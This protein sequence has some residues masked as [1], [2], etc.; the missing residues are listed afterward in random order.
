MAPGVIRCRLERSPILQRTS[1][2]KE[3][4]AAEKLGDKRE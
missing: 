1:P 2:P 4:V 3:P